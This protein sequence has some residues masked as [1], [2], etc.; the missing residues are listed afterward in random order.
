MRLSVASIASD[1]EPTLKRRLAMVSSNK[2]FH[3]E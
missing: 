1:F 3:A 2:R